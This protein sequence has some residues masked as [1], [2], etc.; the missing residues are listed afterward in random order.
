MQLVT[1]MMYRDLKRAFGFRTLGIW[2]VMAAFTVY[3]FFFSNGRRELVEN[4]RLEY[5]SLF[6]PLIIFGAWAVMA[7]FFDLISADRERNVLDCILCSG[8]TKRH[9][10][11]AKIVTT[12][13]VSLVLSFI[14]LAPITIIV[15]CLSSTEKAAMIG[16]YLIPLWG[17]IMVFAALGLM[18]SVFARSSKA[19]MIW[20]LAAGLVLMPRFFILIPEG[21][22]KVLNLSQQTVDNISMISPGIMMEALSNPNNASSWTTAVIG[23]TIGIVVLFGIAYVAFQNQDEYNYGE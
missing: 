6:L 19:A 4:N 23:F 8:T 15:T 11:I 13:I 21:I 9:V 5:M 17:F 20:S 14:Y 3:F 1:T 18:I 22:G 2:A 7:V 12:A 16:K 10:F